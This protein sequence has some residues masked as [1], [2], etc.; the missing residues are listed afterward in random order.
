[1]VAMK[2]GVEDVVMG[3]K[4]PNRKAYT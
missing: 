3:A 4:Y 1:M 2:T